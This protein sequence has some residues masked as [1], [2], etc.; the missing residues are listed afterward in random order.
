[1]T[2]TDIIANVFL[3]TLVPIAKQV[4]MNANIDEK[5]NLHIH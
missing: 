3:V 5:I 1:M 2:W 4:R